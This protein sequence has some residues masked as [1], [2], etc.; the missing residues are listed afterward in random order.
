MKLLKKSKMD[1]NKIR[2][3][4]SF[5][6]PSCLR[7]MRH[8]K[9]EKIKFQYIDAFANEKQKLCDENDIDELPHI[10]ILNKKKEII[11]EYSPSYIEYVGIGKIIEDIKSL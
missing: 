4:G 8:L 11:R 6:C 2:I 3:F 10:Q 5:D 7:L 1:I 9:R